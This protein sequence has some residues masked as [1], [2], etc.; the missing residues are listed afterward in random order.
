MNDRKAVT[1]TTHGAIRSIIEENFTAVFDEV[2]RIRGNVATTEA[3]LLSCVEAGGKVT[4]KGSISLTDHLLIDK[5]VSLLEGKIIGNGYKIKVDNASDVIIADINLEDCPIR[6]SGTC[7]RVLVHNVTSKN[8]TT[9]TGCNFYFVDLDDNVMTD[10]TVRKC[11]F[12]GAQGYAA[13]YLG[14]NNAK[15][16]RLLIDDNT[17]HD[18]VNFGIEFIGSDVET[19]D[20]L[21]RNNRIFDIGSIRETSVGNGCGA[22]YASGANQATGVRVI[23]NDIRRVLEVGIEGEFQEVALNYVEDSGYDQLNHPISDSACIYGRQRNTH[24]NVLV[25][26][27]QAGGFHYATSY[28]EHMNIN[29]NIIKNVFNEWQ[30]ST[31]YSVGDIVVN[32]DF[33]L[34]FSAGNEAAKWYICTGAGTSDASGGPTGETG[35]ITDGT[36]T[37]DYKKPFATAG[38]DLNGY[39]GLQDVHIRDNVVVDI[40][41]NIKTGPWIDNTDYDPCITFVDNLH[42]VNVGIATKGSYLGGYGNRTVTNIVRRD[43][44]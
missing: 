24:D 37:W 18:T 36:V 42:R 35:S 38:M 25:N 23:G 10:I 11:D 44:E 41:D 2:I 19:R 6:L 40:K 14:Y 3:E 7:S 32:G 31:V 5:S 22:I 1:G 4:I 8:C 12:S 34:D 30:P 26:P 21:I 43:L 13:M 20:C 33:S 15:I 29:N 16:T 17:I 39:T 27:G 28:I 9:S